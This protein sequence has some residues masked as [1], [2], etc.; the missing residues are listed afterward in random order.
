M[1]IDEGTLLF[2][3][4]QAQ[5]QAENQRFCTLFRCRG[6]GAKVTTYNG[7]HPDHCADSLTAPL[8]EVR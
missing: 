3:R 1:D 5:I 7:E 2:L 8:A 6:C 4:L